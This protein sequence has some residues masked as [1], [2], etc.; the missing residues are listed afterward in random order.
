MRS[1]QGFLREVLWRP[2]SAISGLIAL[3]L[4]ILS[5]AGLGANWTP[6]EKALVPV[7]LLLAALLVIVLFSSYSLLKKSDR[8][9]SVRT[10]TPGKHYYK[11]Q[12]MVILESRDTVLV[13]DIL[14]LFVREGDTET[15]ICLVSVEAISSKGFP[16]SIVLHGLT[17]E[18]SQ[19]L[20]DES[21]LEQLQAKRGITRRALECLKTL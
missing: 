16:Q 9:L 6:L 21:R 8:P 18:T 7:S 2:R 19:Y 10:V 1:S 4:S 5:W 14:T 3:L 13:G 15:P 17:D 20:R 11:D 12:L